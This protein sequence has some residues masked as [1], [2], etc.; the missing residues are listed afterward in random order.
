MRGLV[1]KQQGLGKVNP[2]NFVTRSG[3]PLETLPWDPHCL[4]PLPEVYEF[5]TEFGWSQWDLW[6]EPTDEVR[7]G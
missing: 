1:C 6:S 2:P 4:M 3:I 7:C 5:P